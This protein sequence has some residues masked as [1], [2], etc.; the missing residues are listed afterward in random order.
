MGK[1]FAL[2]MGIGLAVIAA[3]VA[4]F[5]YLQWGAHVEVTGR[6]LKVRTAPIDEHS[7]MAVVDFR[8]TNP[9]DYPFVVKSVTVILERTTGDPVEGTTVPETDTQRLFA[10]L[11]LLG[12]KYNDSLI[13]RDKIA[14][15]QS[16]DRMVA[17]RIEVP[18]SALQMRKRFVIRIDEV[19]G[20]VSQIVE[21]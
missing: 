18:D 7:S 16:M 9:S 15:R 21:K 8:F 20:G 6:F 5:V 13:A 4:G 19:D 3:G 2:A 17:S 1:Q 14:A 11:P 12:Q 10:G